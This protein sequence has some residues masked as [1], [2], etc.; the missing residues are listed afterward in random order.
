M[1]FLFRCANK[2]NNTDSN[3]W[4]HLR[5]RV[6]SICLKKTTQSA[7]VIQFSQ[8]WNIIFIH[9]ISDV[10]LPQPQFM[11]CIPDFIISKVSHF[12]VGSHDPLPVYQEV[13]ARRYH[14]CCFTWHGTPFAHFPTD[15]RNQSTQCK[16][17]YQFI[18]TLTS[19]VFRVAGCFSASNSSLFEAVRVVHIQ[20]YKPTKAQI[21][22]L[23]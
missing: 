23:Y 2:I 16:M 22:V 3:R 21:R 9:F 7:L 6:T 12:P 14:D 19:L 20:I 10:Q 11:Q 8:I 4:H 17:R 5:L 13:T 15:W 1:Y 18:S